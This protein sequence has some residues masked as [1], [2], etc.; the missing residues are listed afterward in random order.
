MWVKIGLGRRGS[1]RLVVISRIHIYARHCRQIVED[2]ACL[3]GV[4]QRILG[5]VRKVRASWVQE[6][7]ANQRPPM[8][9]IPLLLPKNVAGIWYVSG[10]KPGL[11]QESPVSLQ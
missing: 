4:I 6:V 8:G 9:S 7:V 2:P 1:E 11:T 10:L 5:R 3:G